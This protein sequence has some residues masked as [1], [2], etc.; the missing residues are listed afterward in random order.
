MYC[1]KPQVKVRVS[2]KLCGHHVYCLKP[3][4]TVRVS[5]K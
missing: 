5:G 1:L 2:S 3:Q 4:V